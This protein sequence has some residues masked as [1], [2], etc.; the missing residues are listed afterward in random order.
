MCLEG[1]SQIT[2]QKSLQSFSPSLLLRLI[3]PWH[4]ESSGSK[5]MEW[6]TEE[7]SSTKWEEK[8][9]LIKLLS[10]KVIPTIANIKS[11]NYT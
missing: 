4:T 9:I 5:H 2:V 1:F 8:T 11:Y 10:E 3:L 6:E 7:L